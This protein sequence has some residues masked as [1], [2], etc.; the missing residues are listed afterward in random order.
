MAAKIELDI[1]KEIEKAKG[2]LE[3]LNK[4]L[5]TLSNLGALGVFLLNVVLVLGLVKWCSSWKTQSHT[6][7]EGFAK[8]GVV[9]FAFACLIFVYYVYKTYERIDRVIVPPEIK[10]EKAKNEMLGKAKRNDKARRRD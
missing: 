9:F 8:L 3:S 2:L 4:T 6:I 5:R 10:E 1:D 7:I